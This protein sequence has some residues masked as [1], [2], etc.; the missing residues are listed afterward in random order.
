MPDRG[1]RRGAG[2]GLALDRGRCILCGACVRARP[3][4]FGW[5][6]GAQ[7][8][9]LRR[10]ALVVPEQDDADEAAVTRMRAGLAARVHALRR[11]VHIRHVD[12]GSDG[13][14]EWEVHALLNPVYD[15]GRLGIFFTASPRHADILLVTGA[16]GHG[17]AG[18]LRAHPGG[19][20]RADGGHRRRHRRHQRR[21]DRTHLRGRRRRRR[22]GA[23]RRVGARLAAQPV[24]PAARD[25]ARARPR[26]RAPPGTGVAV[27]ALLVT[28]LA[29]LA[30]A[31][32]LDLV[33]GVRRAWLRPL[34]Y[35]LG[36]AGC[37]CLL[38][39]GVRAVTGAP[40]VI[41][42][43]DV[44]GF[45]PTRLVADPLAGLFL[46]ISCGVAVAVSLGFAS[47]VR[48]AGRAH[49]R[50]LGAAYALLVGAVVVV[51]LAGDAFAFLFAWELVTLA[52]YLLA[53]YDRRRPG[54]AAASWLTLAL[55]K[56]GGAFLLLGFLLLAADAGSFT[57]ASWSAVPPGALRSAAYALIIVGF[58]GEG[59]AGPAAGLDA[60][61]LRGRTRPGP[62]ADGR[63]RGQRRV[64]RAVADARR[65]RRAAAVAG[66]RRAAGRVGH[67]AAR[68]RAR[69]RAG[70]TCSGS[71]PTPAWKT[72]G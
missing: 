55:G 63:G 29:L 54:R 8:A 39:L 71:S 70:R 43:G 51:V 40:A 30:A 53:G 46:T 20:A 44:F 45:G 13:S 2:D 38:A 62:G 47:W 9:R 19:D 48:P 72:P 34:P 60:G 66:D 65:A 61:R 14:E 52:F 32:T 24:Q 6:A 21:A 37:A 16:G 27:T 11:S 17:M 68:H 59:R 5:A 57:L 10:E 7:T 22:P 23:G 35:L 1:H 41:D 26:P 58:A 12:T 56:A 31:G 3:D 33:A 36:A 69:H 64:L 42:A 4:L 67:R 25:P 28:G 18:P 49:G 50:G 15:V